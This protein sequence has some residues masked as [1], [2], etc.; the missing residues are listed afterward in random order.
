MDTLAESR[1]S[2]EYLSNKDVPLVFWRLA[3][4]KSLSSSVR[5]MAHSLGRRRGSLFFG[6]LLL[7]ALAC[8]SATSTPTATPTQ[9]A[10]GPEFSAILVTRDLAVGDNRVVFG[11]VDRN[12][13]PVRAPQ[14]EVRAV[15]FP[16]TDQTTEE[17]RGA[18]TAKF[19][20]WP[21]GQQGVFSTRLDFDVA[22][23]WGLEVTT[24]REDGAPVVA[25]N[26]FEVLEISS[27]PSI[28]A[29]AP[30]SVTPT[31]DGVDDL[32]TITSDPAPDPGLYRLSIDEALDAGQPL[33]VTFSTPAFCLTATCGPQ[34]KV[35]S[36][37]K[38]QYPDRANFI[39]VE[40]LKDPHLSQGGR[41]FDDFVP[42]VAEWGLPNEPWT[43][44]IDKEG[45]VHA[46]FE[47]F[48]TVEEIEAAL[49]EVL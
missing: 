22:G 21:T 30:R 4:L 7:V 37:L 23:F 36:E 12:G 41:S 5:I 29:P 19:I 27:T 31:L 44:I 8:S 25:R 1:Y 11:L 17:E 10:G 16:T 46:K 35:I 43:F 48:T 13:M 34:V 38:D 14:A 47:A 45:R 33:V 20:R 32:A 39:H 15:Y 2:F 42:T 49:K 28:G 18:A 40:V 26:A 24:T 9:P 6:V 3:I